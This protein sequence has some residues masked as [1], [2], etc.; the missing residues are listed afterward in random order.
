V[1]NAE[2]RRVIERELDALRELSYAELRQRIPAKR[3][4][5]L[6]T[7]IFEAMQAATREVRVDSGAVY[8][9]E[10][11]VMWDSKADEEIRVT[12]SVDDARGSAFI[13]ITE[14]FILAPEGRP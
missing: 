7:D 2:A 12:V 8:R 5:F 3:Q 9:V 1:N 4:G 6:F 11:L 13:S 14:S 10:T